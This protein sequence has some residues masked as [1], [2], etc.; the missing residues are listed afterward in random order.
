MTARTHSFKV[1][2]FACLVMQEVDSVGPATRIFS[3]IPE[4]ERNHALHEHGYDPEAIDFS[5]NVMFVNTGAHR[6][7][8]DTGSGIQPGCLPGSLEAAGVKPEDVDT[9]IITHCHRDHIGGIVDGAG[10]FIYPNARYFMWGTEWAYW[11]DVAQKTEDANDPLCRNLPLIQDRLTLIDRETE[12]LPGVCAVPA[13]GHTVGHMALLIESRGERLLHIADTAHHPIQVTLTD[14]CPHFDIQPDLS[15]ITRRQ[16]MERAAREN[17]LC[18]AY[19]FA[20]PGLGYVV[21]QAGE[22]VWQ[23]V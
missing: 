22:L 16:I 1:G 23:K 17:L 20:F 21:E 18:A 13:P 19:H 10:E 6:V 7:M 4:D 12:I 3:K 5:V 8:I 15:R 2:D 14:W 11:L 9:V